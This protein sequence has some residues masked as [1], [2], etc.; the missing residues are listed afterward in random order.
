MNKKIITFLGVVSVLLG[1]I[2]CSNNNVASPNEEI[3]GTG[4]FESMDI[5]P[6]E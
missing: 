6:A 1:C 2:G 3:A 5:I 4:S